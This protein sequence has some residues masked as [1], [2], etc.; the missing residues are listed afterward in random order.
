[1]SQSDQ[2]NVVLLQT[3]MKAFT[4][5]VWR[6]PQW[7]HT[8]TL[9]R[10]SG[11]CLAVKRF[12][13]A[14][15]LLLHILKSAWKP[16]CQQ[17]NYAASRRLCW[18]KVIL[19]RLQVFWSLILSAAPQARKR[20]FLSWL[21]ELLPASDRGEFIFHQGT[22]DHYFIHRGLVP[23]CLQCAAFALLFCVFDTIGVLW[24]PRRCASSLVLCEAFAFLNGGLSSSPVW[25]YFSCIWFLAQTRWCVHAAD[26]SSSEIWICRFSQ[27]A[28]V[29]CL[30]VSGVLLVW[31]ST[32]LV[33][34]V[35]IHQLQGDA[36]VT[37]SCAFF[38]DNVGFVVNMINIFFILPE[39]T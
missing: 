16:T 27:L 4:R 6:H 17:S 7:I 20:D 39:I 33:E 12:C 10:K 2:I 9:R 18:G 24:L 26:L 34:G 36:N 22:D 37:H 23:T 38:L 32:S 5:H 21:L 14:T 29:G 13:S 25:S 8:G 15:L 31:L 28:A 1:M 30:I 35:I 19:L 11:V 3:N